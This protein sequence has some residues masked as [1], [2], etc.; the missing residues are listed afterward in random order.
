[1]E[2]ISPIAERIRHLMLDARISGVELA[3]RAGMTQP[4][5]SRRLMGGVEFRAGDLEAIAAALDVPIHQLLPPADPDH[6]GLRHV[7]PAGDA[8]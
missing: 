5:L 1:M 4:Y 6:G 8:R 2:N 7:T 3:R